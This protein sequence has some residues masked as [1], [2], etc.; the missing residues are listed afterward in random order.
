MY[1]STQPPCGFGWIDGHVSSRNQG[2]CE[3]EERDPGNEVV[4]DWTVDQNV[5]QQV[6]SDVTAMALV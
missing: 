6:Q 5:A 3:A 4:T 1:L 2:L